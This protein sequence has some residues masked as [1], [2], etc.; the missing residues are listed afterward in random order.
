MILVFGCG[1]CAY[2]CCDH[3]DGAPHQVFHV[4]VTNLA[5]DAFAMDSRRGDWAIKY[6]K[7]AWRDRRKWCHH[8]NF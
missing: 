7:D 8:L 5:D 1:I 4:K 2:G 3:A 6:E